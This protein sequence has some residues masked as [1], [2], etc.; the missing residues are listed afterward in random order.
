[1]MDGHFFALSENRKTVAGGMSLLDITGG[2][3]GFLLL[4]RAVRLSCECEFGS[5]DGN[6]YCTD[7][8]KRSQALDGLKHQCYAS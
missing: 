6:D 3:A 1:M 8:C 5:N 2:V 7:Y 4:L